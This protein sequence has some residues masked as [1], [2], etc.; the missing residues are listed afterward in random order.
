MDYDTN[1]IYPNESLIDTNISINMSVTLRYIVIDL[2]KESRYQYTTFGV[3]QT[4][5]ET[6]P[7]ASI[8]AF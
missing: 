1:T 5:F 3:K 2:L 8:R 7:H 4:Q 6:R